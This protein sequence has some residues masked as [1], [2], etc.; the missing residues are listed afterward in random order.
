MT[1][2][3]IK[4]FKMALPGSYGVQSVIA[5]KLNSTRSAVTQFLNKRPKMRILCE[6][7]REKII[8]VS[9]NRLFSAANEGQKWA[10]DKILSTIGKGRGYVETQEVSHSGT[11]ATFNLVTKSVEEI[12]NAKGGDKGTRVD[13]KPQARGNTKSS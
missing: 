5:K 13:N 7:E 11:G 9:E 2:I 8:D 4:T 3:T 6:Q 1:K 10:V 12:K